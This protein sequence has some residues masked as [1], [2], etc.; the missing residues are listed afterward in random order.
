MRISQTLRK[1]LFELVIESSVDFG[2]FTTDDEG[3][4]TSWNIGAERLF[5]YREYDIVGRTADV[6]FTLED[7]Q[8]EV[9]K[10]ER[11]L[12]SQGAIAPGI[13]WEQAAGASHWEGRMAGQ[14]EPATAIT[15]G[16]P[17]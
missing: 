14:S 15:P 1:E 7:R 13:K 10:L 2:I 11:K 5:G 8:R 6:I 17:Q 16:A 4:V 12:A 3:V 9:P